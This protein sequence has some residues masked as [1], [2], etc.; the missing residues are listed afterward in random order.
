MSWGDKA[1]DEARQYALGREADL[2]TIRA[3]EVLI[4]ACVQGKPV[5][6]GFNAARNCKRTERTPAVVLGA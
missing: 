6:T 4:A 3:K 2:L 1:G 5:S